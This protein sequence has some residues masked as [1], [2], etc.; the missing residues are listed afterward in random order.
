MC[1]LGRNNLLELRDVF[2]PQLRVVAVECH[3]A[4]DK[5][6]GLPVR[7]RLVILRVLAREQTSV[8]EQI[9]DADLDRF[10]RFS[11]SI[12]F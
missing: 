3:P 6:F 2:Q 9:S 11:D 5:T 7:H 8:E 10:G 12:C 1:L 4:L